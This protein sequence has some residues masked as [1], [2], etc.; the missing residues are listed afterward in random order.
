MNAKE[1]VRSQDFWEKKKH[2]LQ[3][4]CIGAINSTH[5][6]ANILTKN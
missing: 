2:N 1:E 6:Q 5:V 4:N 3:E